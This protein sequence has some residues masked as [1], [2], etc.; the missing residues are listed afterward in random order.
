MKQDEM[1]TKQNDDSPLKQ[2]KLIQDIEN[3]NL[4]RINGLRS[5]N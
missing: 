5:K 4:N 3:D 1:A 2:S